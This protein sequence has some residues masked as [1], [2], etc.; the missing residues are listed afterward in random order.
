M[1]KEFYLAIHTQR[2]CTYSTLYVRPSVTL[3]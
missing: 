1:M 2:L 3:E